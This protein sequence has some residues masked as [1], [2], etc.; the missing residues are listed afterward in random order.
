MSK[1]V[2]FNIFVVSIFVIYSPIYL[3]RRKNWRIADEDLKRIDYD[4][5]KKQMKSTAYINLI[6]RELWGL[7]LLSGYFIN[8]RKIVE[9]G[10]NWITVT[11]TLL[12]VSFIVWG[13]I[14]FRREI[15]KVDEL[16]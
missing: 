7:I 15:R 4:E 10:F 1:A 2:F 6:S 8:F 3:Q 12:G 11:I 9:F 16:R 13:I 14:G 5:W